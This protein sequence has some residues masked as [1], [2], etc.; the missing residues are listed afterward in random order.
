MVKLTFDDLLKSV[1][2]VQ[3]DLSLVDNKNIKDLYFYLNVKS[4]IVTGDRDYLKHLYT[5]PYYFYQNA[6]IL[7]ELLNDQYFSNT[8]E[9]GLRIAVETFSYESRNFIYES[10]EEKALVWETV[11][12]VLT[13]FHK[14]EAT[15]K[16][17]KEFFSMNFLVE[18]ELEQRNITGRKYNKIKKQF[19]KNYQQ[20][21]LK[22]SIVFDL[23]VLCEL[24]DD[25]YLD[26]VINDIE[27]NLN[28]IKYLQENYKH[29]ELFMS[30][31]KKE[32]LEPTFARIRKFEQ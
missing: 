3:I 21:I 17:Y 22:D 20:E 9:N 15:S 6:K 23:Y 24:E 18:K 5:N 11:N 7:L 31:N 19:L 10:Q 29:D 28:K 1:K 2:E 32:E 30:D 27:P 13:S 16:D 14:L 12:D 26:T 4:A 25:F 8:F